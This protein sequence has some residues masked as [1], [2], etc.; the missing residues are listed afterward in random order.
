MLKFSSCSL[1]TEMLY[2]W[3][4]AKNTTS[5]Q[6]KRE[7]KINCTYLIIIFIIYCLILFQFLQFRCRKNKT[8]QSE[9]TSL[10]TL[11]HYQRKA[12]L[13]TKPETQSFNSDISLE[14][15]RNLTKTIAINKPRKKHKK[16]CFRCKTRYLSN[17]SHLD[18]PAPLYLT[19]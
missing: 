1:T 6:G 3:N 13:K 5:A 15:Q 2:K 17:K 10:Y 18:T 4:K 7:S 14:K 16:L 19:A 8:T 9:F 12:R 11:L